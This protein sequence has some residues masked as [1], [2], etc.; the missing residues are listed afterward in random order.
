[1]SANRIILFLGV[2]FL[3]AA[4]A[5]AQPS[6]PMSAAELQLA[7]SKLTVAGSALYIAAHPDDENTALLAWLASERLVRTGYLSMTRG[8]GGQNLIGSEKGELL[9]VIRTQELLAARR[10]DG[11]EQF[12]TRAVDFGYSKNPGET[13]RIWQKEKVLADVVW[14]IRSFRPDVIISRFP[15]SGAGGHG[16]HTASAILAEEAF[17][18]AADPARFPE[19]LALVKPWQ[20]KRLLWN[21]F[22]RPGAEPPPG[23]LS[24]DLG[25]YNT[26]LGRS[27]T[28]I[29]AD[30]RSM[31]KSQGFGSAERRGTVINRFQTVAG[32]PPQNDLFDGVDLSWNRFPGG[33]AVQS[34]F[35]RA[36]REFQPS[37]PHAVVPLLMEADRLIGRLNP[38]PL[39][40][41]K[42]RD[43]A[44]AVRAAAGLWIEA[45]AE[46]PETS[47]GSEIKVAATVVNRSPLPMNLVAV[48]SPWGQAALDAPARLEHN[49]LLTREMTVR[50]PQNAPYSHPYW[51]NGETPQTWISR[52]E[53][54][55]ALPVTFQIEIDGKP[56]SFTVPTLYRTV[57]RVKGEV[58]R[59]FI[60]APVVTVEL[61]Q[62][63]QVF[64]SSQPETISVRATDRGS[65]TGDSQG[66]RIDSPT[67]W[68]VTRLDAESFRIAPPPK[69]SSDQLV[70]SAAGSDRA[71]VVIDY[72]H[73]PRQTLFP[74]ATSRL[75]RVDLSKRGKRIGYVMGP[76]D[77]VPTALGEIGYEV[78]LLSDEDLHRGNLSQ[79]DAIVTGVR[80]YN[81]RAALRQSQP[82]L[83]DYVK[84]GG[85]LV[86]QYNT[87]D[88]SL[89]QSLGPFP[90]KISRD[91]VTVE[92]APVSFV[93]A[94]HPLL[95]APNRI[96]PADFEGWVQER[97]L[98]F[99]GEW[100]AQYQPVI[101]T[102]DPG[103]P[104]QRGSILYAPYGKGVFI[105]T[106]LSFFRQLPA[107]VPGAYRIF[108]NLVSARA[109]VHD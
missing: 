53:N 50:V 92:E 45:I 88:E 1:M 62:T 59:P 95:T 25:A 75:V 6:R 98:Y 65:G 91:R 61:P 78:T 9:G 13:L 14:L 39:I 35:Q 87:S 3:A 63:P 31:H 104:E 8:E 22:T 26:L 15:A 40:E 20:P 11:A 54:P 81:I 86:A 4:E 18:A 66:V 57:D 99:P 43:L 23:G 109:S 94:D 5:G 27:Y 12:F 55:P 47:A 106:G 96:T 83:L 67:G 30:S 70:A 68:S 48:K 64:T 79:Y 19:Q 51:L 60:V 28:E 32:E 100:D 7:L 72:D 44:E 93:R 36:A 80:A 97:G 21:S 33:E 52:A 101:A 69:Q 24:I 107:G 82:R 105:Y 49:K 2:I 38:E 37:H 41:A 102:A 16:H 90:L 85:T 58:Y 103:E 56:L 77:D 46:A 74:R 89:P 76:G 108:A 42:R 71:R 29:A 73:I 34:I 84:N 17:S 10:I